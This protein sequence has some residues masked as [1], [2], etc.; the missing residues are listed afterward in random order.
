VGTRRPGVEARRL[1][2]VNDAMNTVRSARY[3]GYGTRELVVDGDPPMLVL[4]HGFGLS[5]D[6]WRPV[7]DRLAAAGRS[8]VAV[9][10]PGFGHADPTLAGPQLPQLD[11]FVAELIVHYGSACPVALVGN[12]LGALMTVRAAAAQLPVRAAMPLCAAGFG[13]T[14]PIRLLTI[15][16]LQPVAQLADLPVPQLIWRPFVD[17]VAKRLTFADAT[18]AD[19]VMVELLTAPLRD[20][21]AARDVMTA[22]VAYATEVAT[23]QRVGPINCPVTVVH[24]GRDRI[25]SLA[26]SRRLHSLIPHSRFVVLE[27]A[28]HCPNLDA[29]DTVTALAIQLAVAAQE[30]A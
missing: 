28:G 9:D 25:V 23:H 17:A 14:T 22:A 20:R 18:H 13:W 11:A 4:L 27:K 30:T 12:S 15:G 7:L 24:G 6:C 8:A 10:L 21:A 16:N 5:A 1:G 3:A 29:P 19:R 2:V 26:A